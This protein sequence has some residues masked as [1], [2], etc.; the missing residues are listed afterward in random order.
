METEEEVE[1]IAGGEPEVGKREEA[2]TDRAK[3]IV[4]KFRKNDTDYDSETDHLSQIWIDEDS[5]DVESGHEFV[6][7]IYQLRS[8]MENLMVQYLLGLEVNGFIARSM[9]GYAEQEYFTKGI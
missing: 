6:V 4:E 7:E 2:V 3:K 8:T 5:E 1:V 9:Q